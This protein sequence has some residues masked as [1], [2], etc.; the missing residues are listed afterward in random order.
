MKDFNSAVMNLLKK[1]KYFERKYLFYKNISLMKPDAII[2]NWENTIVK[3]K[4]SYMMFYRDLPFEI[5]DPSL[6]KLLELLKRNKIYTAIVSNKD[7]FRLHDEIEKL[8]FYKYFNKIVGSGD[9]PE[10]KPS[11]ECTIRAISDTDIEF[12]ENIWIIG[13]SSVDMEFAKISSATGILFDYKNH[14]N[15]KKS[16]DSLAC[17]LKINTFSEIID[18]IKQFFEQEKNFQEKYNKNLN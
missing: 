6:I 10:M 13:D 18:I 12:G 11:I 15:S 2:F 3:R 5:I 16:L 4:N 7:K 17:V 8:N 1:A 9:S 14:H